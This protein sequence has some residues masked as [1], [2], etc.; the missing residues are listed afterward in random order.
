MSSLGT[1]PANDDVHEQLRAEQE[2]NLL[3]SEALAEIE[4]DNQ[5]W[6]RIDGVQQDD[7]TPQGLR[8]IAAAARLNWIANP[9]IRRAVNVRTFYTWGQ[10]VQLSA[11]DDQVNDLV[12]AFLDDPL[13]QQE[14]FS[15]QARE[16][17]DR[18]LQLDGNL[19]LA[20]FTA[21]TTGRVQVRS[22]PW[23]EITSVVTAPEDSAQRWFYLREWQATTTDAG[24]GRVVQERRKALYPDLS[25]RPTVRPKERGGVEVLW[26]SPVL[27]VRVGGLKG[28]QFGVSEV[29]SALAW[30][31]AYKGFLEDWAALAKALSRFA[32]KG[33]AKASR[34]GAMRRTLEG[35]APGDTGGAARGVLPA[36][37]GFITDPDTDLTPISKTGA[38][39]DAESGRPLAMMVASAMDIPYTILM[40]DPDIG[41]LATAKTL[42]RPLELAMQSRR[43]LWAATLRRLCDYA[44]D[45]SIRAPRG[46]LQGR[47]TRDEFNREIAT[48]S[49]DAD[50]N[51]DIEWPS[52]LEHDQKALVDAIVAADGTGHVPPE[53]ICRLLLVALGVENVDELMDELTDDEGKFL[54]PELAAKATAAP[55]V[56][57][58][59]PA[60]PPPQEPP[61]TREAV[62]EATRVPPPQEQFTDFEQI[63]S[64]WQTALN[65]A[66]IAYLAQREEDAE[67]LAGQVATGVTAPAALQ[68]ASGAAAGLIL[69]ALTRLHGTAGARAVAEVAAQGQA[70]RAPDPDVAF[71]TEH[72]D[73][74]ADLLTRSLVSSAAREALRLTGLDDEQVAQAVRAHLATLTDAQPRELIG[75]ALTAAQN[76]AREAVFGQVVGGAFYASERLDAA[77]CGPC[78]DIDGTRYD[79]V[80]EAAEAYPTGGYRLCQGR[81]RCR[82]LIVFWLGDDFPT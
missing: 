48:L 70:V 14:L 12:Q 13:N 9:L 21:P 60:A 80:I 38:T 4:Q 15:Q 61:P 76:R 5:G 19:T 59:P 7:L 64:E 3:L 71:L 51:L 37:G 16:E 52:I 43:E 63:Q 66:V 28:M 67:T 41:N 40:G 50:R 75:G 24:S 25:Y 27:H 49:G 22:L 33:K 17:S 54:D 18:A 82:G 31:R 46:A 39:I 53:T 36:G 45:Q 69:A 73:V 35:A 57:P 30:A 56:P 34:V 32:W 8:D 68:L 78:V 6:R 62:R 42:D 55:P 79:T 72:A 65:A 11:R 47:I 81:E 1:A 29:Y 26:D 20:L 23:T 44:I 58:L 2:T 10:G 77:T 74:V